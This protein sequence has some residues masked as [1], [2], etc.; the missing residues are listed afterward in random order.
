MNYKILVVDDE[1]ANLRLLERL[2]RSEYQVISAASGDDALE[3]LKRHDF[4]LIISDQ[5]MPGMTGIEFLKRAAAMRPHTVRIILTGY[6]DVNA[7]V[8]VIN[9]GVVYKYVAKPWVNED[10]QQTIVRAIEH[11]ETIKRQYELTIQNERL[12]ENVNR[13]ERLCVRLIGETLDLKDSFLHQHSQRVSGYAT[14]AG[15]RLNLSGA[16]LEQL[17]LA[18]FL[19]KVGKIG[20]PDIFLDE[21]SLLPDDEYRSREH[22]AERAVQMLASIPEMGEIAAAIRHHTEY[23]NG[24]GFPENLAA[25]QI[26]LFSRI[27]AVAAAYD[28]MTMPRDASKT[29][30]SAEAV[31]KLRDGIGKQF[32]GNVVEAFCQIESIEKIRET[33]ESGITGMQLSKSRIVCDSENMCIGDV[34]QKFKTEPLLALE[35]LKTGNADPNIKPTAELMSLMSK[36]GEAKLRF[37]LDQSGLPADDEFTKARTIYALRRAVAAQLLAAHT[38][39]IHPDEAYTL[40]L[41][42]DVGETLLIKLF[43][44]EM[45][46]LRDFDSK[47]RARQ[48][49]E[50]FGIDAAQISRWMLETCGL[51]RALTSTIENHPY[52][53]RVNNPS[54]LLMQMACEIAETEPDQKSSAMNCIESSTLEVLSLSRTDLNKIFDRVNFII[55]GR[56]ETPEEIP[57]LV[58]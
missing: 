55:D 56:V 18:A 5:R 51:P 43:R 40:G 52:F 7:L 34:L 30:S 58:Y 27:I 48:Q 12:V 37:L 31:E 54:A 24:T 13:M 20:I 35:V 19:H 47:L 32:D 16:E 9:S 50:I 15:Y 26:P 11:Y 49:V 3:L 23:F 6:T 14:A 8:E 10:L 33:I 53:M 44:D 29:L 28:E 25:D 2:F 1:P 46:G 17:S 22:C 39:V 21:T 57:E 42:Y 45:R 4:A 41:L 36:I 38:G